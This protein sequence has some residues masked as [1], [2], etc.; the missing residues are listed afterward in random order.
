MTYEEALQVIGAP[1][2]SGP[3]EIRRACSRKTRAWNPATDPDGLRR[4]REAQ[5]VLLAASPEQPPPLPPSALRSAAP[6][7]QPAAPFYE[8]GE[9]VEPWTS[10]AP[11][12]VPESSGRRWLVITGGGALLFGALWLSLLWFQKAN[13]PSTVQQKLYPQIKPPAPGYD[14]ARQGLDDLCTVRQ[15]TDFFCDTAESILAATK[16]HKCSDARELRQR[17]DGVFGGKNPYIDPV[18]AQK[19]DAFGGRLDEEIAR[20]WK[21]WNP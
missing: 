14:S 19:L 2:G 7:L 12:P 20:C 17:I 9:P 10:R 8:P 18:T 16:Q 21:F 11:H 13:A 5:D 1:P 15:K 6:A 4:L 3:D